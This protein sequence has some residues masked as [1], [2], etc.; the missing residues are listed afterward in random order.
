MKD[1]DRR[2]QKFYNKWMKKREKKWLYV[3][4]NGTILWG[5]PMAI[6]LY[7]SHNNFEFE[8]IDTFG[9]AIN[10]IAF[11]IAGAI[12]GLKQFNN[13]EKKFQ[14]LDSNKDIL[15]GIK[16]LEEGNVWVYENLKMQ[17]KSDDTLEIQNF[18]CQFLD[19]EKDFE[20]IQYC[21][22]SILLDYERLERNIVFFAFIDAKFVKL[23]IFSNA[24]NS[25]PIIEKI[26]K[27][28]VI[29]GCKQ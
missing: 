20:N 2:Q 27:K 25:T 9:L 4:F 26:I 15:K 12:F 23:Q 7:L 17:L 14:E 6:I 29:L 21:E 13:Q 19:E 5:V 10:F 18:L 3:F 8:T 16:I 28:P 24:N 1:L 22:K 11:G